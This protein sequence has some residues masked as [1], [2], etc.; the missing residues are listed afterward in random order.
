MF[1]KL[2]ILCSI[3]KNYLLT[4]QPT[5][6]AEPPL[7]IE[8]FE[9]Q[10]VPQKGVIRLLAK[11]LGEPVPEVQWLFN[12]NP[13]LPNE[14]IEQKYDGE[15]IEL[16]IKDAN[17]E[18]DSGDYKCIASNPLGKTS[19]GARVIVEVDKIKF[20]K[21]LKASITIEEVQSLTLE[22]E[23]S[24]VVLTKWYFNGKELSGM[25]HR[26]VI[27]EGKTHKLFIKNT[28]LR[29]SGKYQCKVKNQETQTTVEV[30]KRK[31]EFVKV[32]EDYEVTEKDT[33]ILDVE[34]ST[35]VPEVKW[36]KDGKE[37]V[38][39]STRIDCIKDDKVHRLIIRNITV[40]DEGQYSCRIEDQECKAEMTV[41]ELPPEIIK[42]LE[43]T[44]VTEGENAEFSI[45]LNKG[46]ALVKWYKDGK[47]LPANERIQHSIDGKRHTITI[48]NAKPSDIG[49]YTVK[50][51]EQ[52]SSATLSVEEPLVDFVMRLPD[53]TIATKNTDAEFTVQ[54]S[55]P[56]VEVTWFM[57]GKPIKPNN[58][59]EVFVE[60]TVRRLVIHNVQ[61]DEAGEISCTAANVTTST[62]L[63]VEEVKTAPII[64]SD[65]NQTVKVKE[66]DDVTMTVKYTGVPKPEAEWTTSKTVKIKPTKRAI[67]NIDEQSASLTLRKV[68]EEDEDVYTV[69]LVNPVGEA[70]AH[71]NLVIM[72][73][74]LLACFLIKLT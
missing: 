37:I 55:K 11:V 72:R 69:R 45:E 63:C 44:T 48:K 74:F 28:T 34:I 41:I 25:D 7:F 16:I 64:I 38:P 65:K 66:N 2:H 23:T 58:K 67:P 4:E 21:K 49:K 1:F 50:V 3:I 47:E 73:K 32:I 46:D 39:D 33:A 17:P 59:Y 31:P 6:N 29:D 60:G 62:K 14:R 70:E 19:H 71:I 56:D 57:K 13:L 30:L 8:R 54:L 26:V 18:T 52:T 40:H 53:V 12:N 9:E 51:G 20:T 61:D 43:D 36:F 35:D 42:P 15:N 27:E 10:I 5:G 68:V 22:C 24:H